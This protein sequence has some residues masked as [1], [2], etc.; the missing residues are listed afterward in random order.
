MMALVERSSSLYVHGLL[1]RTRRE[2]CVVVEL[3]RHR[4]VMYRGAD[5]R[6]SRPSV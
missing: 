6:A 5:A 4:C 1:R 2:A 3:G